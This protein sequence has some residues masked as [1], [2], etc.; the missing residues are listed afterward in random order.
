[1]NPEVIRSH[2]KRGLTAFVCALFILYGSAY[3]LTPT[4]AQSPGKKVLTVDDYARWRSI[5]G[6]QISGD[7]KWVAYGLSYSNTVPA[8]A[9]PVLHILNLETNQDVEVA[10]ATGGTFSPDS[11]WIAYQVDPS[12]GRGGRGAR[13]RSGATPEGG[14]SGAAPAGSVAAPGSTQ[15]AQGRGAGTEAPTPPRRVELRNLASGDDPIVAGN[16]VV[17]VLCKLEP[18]DP[19]EAPGNRIGH[20]RGGI[21]TRRSGRKRARRRRN[22]NGWYSVRAARHRRH[23]AQ[24]GDRAH[25]TP[26][27]RRR[28]CL[29]QGR[30]T[31]RLHRG[32]RLESGQRPFCF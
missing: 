18:Y 2:R 24:P 8:D 1:M 10:N 23:S 17:H 27:Q 19:E 29:Q 26:G 30:R 16:R 11:R 20:D 13:G 15:G 6:Q 31:A 14:G 12:G 3:L 25:A 28:H 22:R 5:S 4:Q 7:G 21:R 32:C 9:K